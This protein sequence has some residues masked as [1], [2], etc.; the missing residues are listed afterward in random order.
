MADIRPFRAFRPAKDK[1]AEIAALPYDVYSREEAREYVASHPGCFLE[2]DR[3]ETF[4]EEGHD[5]YAPEVYEKA[6][7][8]L[9][10]RI[11]AG[12]FVQ[13][14]APYY[15]LYEQ[16]F[17]GRT[18]T[19]IV[20]VSSIDDYVGGI[21]KKHENTREEKEQDRIRHVDVC[22][23]QTGPIFLCYRA[24]ADLKALI[25]EVKQRTPEAA[26]DGPDGSKNRIFVV[27]DAQE[28]DT[29]RK[30]FAET[31]AVYIADGH[32]R[33]ASAV[34]VGLKRREA[35]PEA[36][37]LESDYFLSVLFADDEL[38]ILDYNRV[39][40]DLNGMDEETLLKRLEAV[41]SVRALEGLAKDDEAALRPKKKGEMSMFLS[42][43][44]YALGIHDDLKSDDPVR[45]LDA[46]LLQEHI[47]TAILGIG[48]IRTDKRIDFVGGIRG[49]KELERRCAADCKVAFA[50][51][52]TSIAELF[53]VA[54][55]GLLMPPKSTWFE[56]KL[57]SGLFIHTLT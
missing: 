49:L 32:H 29:I 55:Q 30:A 28:I 53:A 36:K 44:W 27:R 9:G 37:H 47:L 1:T 26:F 22:D 16:T 57:L 19:G 25:A 3:P 35:H 23:T 7:E 2:I 43:K 39:V 45:G 6:H 54:D 42:D 20:A 8:V 52:P 18:Q 31:D 48:D 24:R 21:I 50:L 51:Y 14:D 12:D 40:K 41:C 10:Q 15:Y 5:M 46:S 11:E 34:K 4:F 13:D 38:Q 33:C 56:P 17:L